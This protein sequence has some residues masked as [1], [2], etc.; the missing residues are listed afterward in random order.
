MRAFLADSRQDAYER[1]VDELL[2][3]PGYGERWGRHW[4]DIWRYSDWYGRRD[5]DDQRNSARNIWHW[6]DWIIESLNQDKGYDRMIVEMLAA[7][8]LYP[9]D[10]NALRATGYLARDF[11]RFNRNVWMQD[12]V[13][14][15]SAA[16][17][18]ITMKCARCHD[19]KY[20]PISQEEYY[21]FRAFF[22]PYD[23]RVDRIPGQ[24]DP[25]KDG[26]ARV[27][28]GE[29]RQ[30]T[31]E[32]PYIAPIYANTY[33]LIRGDENNPDKSKALDPAPPEVLSQSELQ[34]KTVTLPVEAFNPDIRTFV[35][36]DLIAQAG[37]EVKKAEKKLDDA[38]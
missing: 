4:M 18:G 20:D 38:R 13:E 34:I 7:D 11:Y 2:A 3:S 30:G 28:E 19:H 26:I 36:R 27:F 22:E 32:A 29:P 23:V 9:T 16:F 33:R 15:T 21:R 31:S 5:G 14:H 1:V 25:D 6:R 8:E 24:S 10:P 12:V 17:L 37:A 35:G